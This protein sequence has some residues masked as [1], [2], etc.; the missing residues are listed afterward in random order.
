MKSIYPFFIFTGILPLL[1][2]SCDDEYGPRKE[3][4]PVFMSAVVSPATFAFGDSVM[5]TAT[6]NDPA[7]LLASLNYE[8]ISDGRSIT[9]GEIP[10]SGD[11]AE[12]TRALFIPLLSNQT[13]NASVQVNLIARNVLKGT[14]SYAIEGLTGKRPVYERLYLVTDNGAATILN[15]LSADKNKFAGTDLTLDPSFRFRI[16]ERLNADKSIDYTGD[17]YGKVNGRIGMIDMKGESAFIYTPNADYTKV[18]TFDNTSFTL[19]TT[20]DLLGADDFALSAFGNQD[21]ENESFRTITRTLENGKNYTLF[22][23][24]ADVQNIYNPDFF[25]RTSESSV[26]FLGKTDEYTLYYNP[27][28]KNIF[29]GVTNPSYPDYLLACGWGLGYPTRVT[30]A[31]I[32]SVYPDHRRTHT[33]WGFGNVMNYVLLRRTGEGVYQ[34][35]FYTPGDHDHYAGFKPFENTGWGNEKRAGDFT[36]TGEQII[37][38][39][40][41]WTIANGENDPI[42]ESANYRFTINV[43]NQTVHI[44]KI[45]L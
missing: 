7:T 22:G 45:T 20:G 14:A 42:V 13:D 44:E 33:S 15:V 25:E 29:V 6:I 5:L 3:S 8:V 36:F 28:R 37:T 39:D 34:G 18:L 24:L 30:S 4:T 35:T 16:A 26:Q 23:A 41:D 19:T 2:A 12:I 17:V 32:G 38:G 10:L 1:F 40:N 9:T 21:I 43:I 11:T 31:E 27:V